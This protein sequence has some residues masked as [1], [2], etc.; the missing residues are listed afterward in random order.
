MEVIISL[1]VFI[2]QL[3]PTLVF[4][5]LINKYSHGNISVTETI[6][7]QAISLIVWAFLGGQPMILVGLTGPIALYVE[8]LY[9]FAVLVV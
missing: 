7:G 9:E 2:S 1:L 6:I 4:A 3:S 8:I 5:V